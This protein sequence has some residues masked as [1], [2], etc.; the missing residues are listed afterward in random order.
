MAGSGGNTNRSTVCLE[1]GP[2]GD[3]DPVRA[4]IVPVVIK[5]D[6][7]LNEFI[8]IG[9]VLC[10]ITENISFGFHRRLFKTEINWGCHIE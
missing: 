3:G 7:S 5:N 8:S 10:K 6:N 9:I 1:Y 2:P 4:I